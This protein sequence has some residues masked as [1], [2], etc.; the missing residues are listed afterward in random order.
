MSTTLLGEIAGYLA[1]RP[2]LDELEIADGR[3]WRFSIRSLLIATCWIAAVLAVLRA[4]GALDP[5]RVGLFVWWLM[6]QS[7][8]F[9]AVILLSRRALQVSREATTRR[10][11]QVVESAF[12][13]KSST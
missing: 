6:W 13:A 5:G 1:A 7:A 9:A 2:Y 3:K 10:S 8:L 12:E 4:T 11:P